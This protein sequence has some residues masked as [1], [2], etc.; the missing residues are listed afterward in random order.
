MFQEVGPTMLNENRTFFG[1]RFVFSMNCPR[2]LVGGF[3]F[4]SVLV[5]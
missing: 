5:L 2:Q 4:S 1:F 3:F